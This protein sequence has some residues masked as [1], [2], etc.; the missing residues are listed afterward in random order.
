MARINKSQLTRI[1]I[2]QVATKKFLT[3]GYTAT[4]IKA[5]SDELMMSTGNLTFYFPTKE[6]LLAALVELLCEFQQRMMEEETEEGY[7]SLMALC[8]ELTAMASM[9]EK[10][11]VIRDFYL[12]SYSS[13]MA[14]QII[15]QNDAERAKVVF[16]DTC[17]HWTDE[18]FLE[19]ET[20]VSGIE[21]ATLMKTEN[22]ASLETRIAGALDHIMMIYGIPE[23]TRKIK[24]EKVLK[25]DYISIGNKIFD[26][27]IAFAEE[28][29]EQAI[30]SLLSVKR[31]AV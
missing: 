26:K 13:P 8:L 28:A 2:I 11:E 19:A 16:T 12:A 10:N 6:H 9:C 20:L 25:M 14:L 7:S 15:R 31:K 18:Q 22:S 1:E 21:Y 4:S 23:E 24:I 30:E 29:T 3:N 5:I 17:G 27:F